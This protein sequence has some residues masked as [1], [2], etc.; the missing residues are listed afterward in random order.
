MVNKITRDNNLEVQGVTFCS[1]LKYVK[2]FGCKYERFSFQF[3]KTQL[4]PQP[5][6]AK[7]DIIMSQL[8]LSSKTAELHEARENVSPD[9][10]CLEF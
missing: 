1:L 7:I 8:K 3:Q 10:G 5:I 9:R 2:F 4:S 6:G